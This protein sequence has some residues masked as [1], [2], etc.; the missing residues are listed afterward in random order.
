MKNLLFIFSFFYFLG[1][2]YSP[3]CVFANP[4]SDTISS[5]DVNDLNII[6]PLYR[7]AINPN[8]P[9]GTYNEHSQRV[10]NE[11]LIPDQIFNT[12]LTHQFP[13]R[14]LD[15]LPILDLDFIKDLRFW[16]ITSFR[17][18]ICD[19]VVGG[20]L[21]KLDSSRESFIL[22]KK[23]DGC[24][25]RIRLVAQPM[26]YSGQFLATA[27]HL[28]YNLSQDDVAFLIEELKSIKT[29]T[30]DS[31]GVNTNGIPL[32]IHPG[33]RKEIRELETRQL[34]QK[35]K[36]AILTTLNR[37]GKSAFDRLKIVTAIIHKETNHW[38]M[39]GGAVVK[40]NWI[41]ATTESNLNEFNKR[42]DINL[43]IGTEEIKCDLYMVCRSQP[44]LATDDDK[45]YQ[46]NVQN[47]IKLNWLF[48]NNVSANDQKKEYSLEEVQ[49]IAEI[50]DNPNR[51]HFFNTNCISCHE[52]S[53]F[54]N[55]NKLFFDYEG[56][57]GAT[58]FTSKVFIEAAPN[59][60]INFGYVG[61]VARISTRTASEGVKS[62]TDLN[63]Y[64]NIKSPVQKPFNP[65]ALW[66]CLMMETNYLN[67]PI[68][69][70]E[71]PL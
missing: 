20:E 50:I 62:T 16:T 4:S 26:N 69:K 55:G 64:L 53:N 30:L 63:N 52:S 43:P 39:Y 12:A 14:S 31:M 28:V 32:V 25:P 44:N 5:F 18:S 65:S 71:T 66:T 42:S 15:Q 48:R 70:K 47:M 27:L 8:I 51:V 13:N 68:N 11:G 61:P 46:T 36:S 2:F 56:T 19:D 23:N 33:L 40:G 29:L 57:S 54:R 24:Q 67:C 59:S 41:I 45:I 37:Q 35:V 34:G 58:P 22:L 60:V 10:E 17:F 38:L 7:Q 6:F 9:L 3:T 21:K 49:K 1:F